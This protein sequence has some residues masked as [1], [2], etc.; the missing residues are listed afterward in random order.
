MVHNNFSVAADELLALF[1]LTPD[2]VCIANRAGYFKNF[3]PAVINTLGYSREELLSQP[4]KDFIHPDDREMTS[5]RRANLLKGETMVNFQNRYITK[6][7]SVVWLEWSSIYI[8]EKEMVFAIAKNI[9]ARKQIEQQV[10]DE[11]QKLRDRAVNLKTNIERDR[12]YVA[13][14]LHEELAQMAT[15]VKVDI[16]WIRSNAEGNAEINKRIDHAFVTSNILVDTI[17]RISF[18][19]SPSMLDDLGLAATLEWY[20]E[21]FSTLNGITCRFESQFDE[22]L[23]SKELR[24][25]FFRICQETLDHVKTL[26]SNDDIEIRIVED[27]EKIILSIDG[28]NTQALKTNGVMP[29]HER[30]ESFGGSVHVE[31]NRLCVE[32]NLVS[33][34]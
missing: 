30:V 18:S 5:I 8:P 19:I 4:I 16:D 3:N 13:A 28:L 14:E 23:L 29:L 9:T 15:S 27:A 2:F 17:K 21:E 11:N 32:C 12:K 26:P 6:N 33:L 31:E 10:Y 25:D 24:L 1:Q 20:C 22:S 34:Y 7:G